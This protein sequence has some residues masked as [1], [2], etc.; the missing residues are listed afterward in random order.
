MNRIWI[1]VLVLTVAAGSVLAAQAI[2]PQ[3]EDLG[4]QLAELNMTLQEIKQVLA[5][6]LETASL[7]LMLRRSELVSA[8]VVRLETRL[9]TAES[10]RDSLQFEIEQIRTQIEGWEQRIRSGDAEDSQEYEVYTRQ[11]ELQMERAQSRL[12]TLDGEIQVL[13]NQLTA[14]RRDLQSWQDLVDRR[15]GGV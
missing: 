12:R 13:Q 7:D 3:E 5:E 15:L 4:A 8:D 1:A 11:M 2:A 14:K 6:R 10:E 9:R